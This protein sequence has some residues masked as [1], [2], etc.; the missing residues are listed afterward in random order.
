MSARIQTEHGT[1][2]RTLRAIARALGTPS[3]L[4]LLSVTSAAAADLFGTVTSGGKPVQQVTTVRLSKPGQPPIEMK[5]DTFGRFAFT[6]IALGDYVLVC[7]GSQ[8]PVRVGYVNGLVDC[9]R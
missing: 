4:A 7:G 9:K 3:V 8:I 2:L 5:T 6:G 1:W